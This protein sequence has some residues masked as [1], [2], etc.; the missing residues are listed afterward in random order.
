[1][2]DRMQMFTSIPWHC[3]LSPP[4]LLMARVEQV[5]LTSAYRSDPLISLP[6]VRFYASILSSHSPHD[7]SLPIVYSFDDQSGDTSMS[8]FNIG[9]APSYLFSVIKDIMVRLIYIITIDQLTLTI[10]RAS[11]RF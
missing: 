8:D 4:Q 7:L 3:C 5:S 2:F 10:N 6:V 1:M 9:A 11:T